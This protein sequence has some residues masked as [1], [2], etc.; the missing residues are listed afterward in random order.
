MFE[1]KNEK[2]IEKYVGDETKVVI[3]EGI[4]FIGPFAFQGSNIESIVFPDS[5]VGICRPI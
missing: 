2:T 4:K 1:Y 3:P 5:F